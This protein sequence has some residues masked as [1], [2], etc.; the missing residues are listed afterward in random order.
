MNG[1]TKNKLKSFK[2]HIY[3]VA[4]PLLLITLCML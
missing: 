3:Y 2:G 1:Y 4:L